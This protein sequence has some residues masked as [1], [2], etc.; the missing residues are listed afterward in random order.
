M[1]QK[2]GNVMIEKEN[3]EILW[4]QTFL[5]ELEKTVSNI[6]FDTYI[7]K[8]NPVDL[9]GNKIV[10]CTPSRFFADTINNGTIGEKMKEAFA[11]CNTYITDFEIVLADNREQ[12]LKHLGEEERE[13][14]EMQGSPISPKF[15]FEEFVV[16][17]S[18]E[19]AFAAAKAVAENPGD[20][21]NPL[22]IYGGTGLGKTHLL[23]GIANYLKLCAGS[24]V[25]SN[26]WLT[27]QSR[28]SLF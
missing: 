17:P 20:T 15:T 6:A 4:E 10:L 27:S 16:G 25:K 2:K 21:Y 24:H 22:F 1:Q 26:E 7:N 14:L 8:L 9:K 12:Y 13:Q 23:M 3:Y 18:N 11:K 5:P 19:Y 28:D